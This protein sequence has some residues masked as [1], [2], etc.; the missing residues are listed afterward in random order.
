M[1]A[2]AALGEARL[3]SGS[4]SLAWLY[5][6]ARRRLVD[7][8]RASSP[9]S[10]GLNGESEAQAAEF[11]PEVARDPVDA[12]KALEE[13]RRR[14]IVLKLFEGRP[15]SSQSLLLDAARALTAGS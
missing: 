2:V 8:L 4:D 15:A 3:Q 12:V 5:T 10:V 1:A 9:V 11:G 14:V 7:R 13:S 6:V